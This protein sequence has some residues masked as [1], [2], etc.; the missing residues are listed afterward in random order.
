MVYKKK[1]KEEWI[2]NKKDWLIFCH[3]RYQ[4]LHIPNNPDVHQHDLIGFRIHETGRG[5]VMTLQGNHNLWDRGGGETDH[6]RW[7]SE[8]SGFETSQKWST[9]ERTPSN[10]YVKYFSNEASPPIAL[11]F[12]V[13]HLFFTFC[14]VSPSWVQLYYIQKKTMKED[15]IIKHESYSALVKEWPKKSLLNL[16]QVWWVSRVLAVSRDRR[17]SSSIPWDH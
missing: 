15:K 11:V 1:K 5:V 2:C 9:W 13:R 8:W 17:R 7:C 16:N 3:T 12:E 14:A 10:W 6:V 4:Q